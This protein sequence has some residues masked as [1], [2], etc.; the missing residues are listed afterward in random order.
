[1][2][3]PGPGPLPGTQAARH[4]APSTC[5]GCRTDSRAHHRA[6]RPYAR[7]S[8]HLDH[9]LCPSPECRTPRPPRQQ[10]RHHH[11]ARPLHRMQHRRHPRLGARRRHR[12][13]T[14]RPQTRPRHGAGV[15]LFALAYAAFAIDTTSIVW[16]APR[17]SPQASRSAASKPPNTPPSPRLLPNTSARLGVRAARHRCS[18]SRGC[19]RARRGAQAGSSP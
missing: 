7:S 12:R 9:L 4:Q 14:R 6:A 16:L 17:S 19:S 2:A 10:D 18:A 8:L 3:I 13:P 5:S 1:V 11:R 15:A